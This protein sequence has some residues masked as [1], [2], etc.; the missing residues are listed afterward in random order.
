MVYDGES[1]WEECEWDIFLHF[2]M[3]RVD[4][5]DA[6][7]VMEYLWFIWRLRRRTQVFDGCSLPPRITDWFMCVKAAAYF[8]LSLLLS[9]IHRS[10]MTQSFLTESARWREERVQSRWR[11]VHSSVDHWPPEIKTV[12]LQDVR[13]WNRGITLVLRCFLTQSV[14]SPVQILSGHSDKLQS[15]NLRLKV[16]KKPLLGPYGTPRYNFY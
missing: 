14:V 9:N 12:L 8:Y 3:E 15:T 4:G 2:R 6:V 11:A 16:H 7:V 13:S 1:K 10:S 5:D